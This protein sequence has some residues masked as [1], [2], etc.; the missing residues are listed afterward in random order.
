MKNDFDIINGS[1]VRKS[2]VIQTCLPPHKKVKM[3]SE[4]RLTDSEVAS[5]SKITSEKL[6]AIKQLS[7]QLVWNLRAYILNLLRSPD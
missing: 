7:F 1:Q 6:L 2:E 4:S 3:S 5:L